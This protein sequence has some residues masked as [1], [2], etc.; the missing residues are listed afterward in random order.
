MI[1]VL[2]GAACGA[3]AGVPRPVPWLD[4]PVRAGWRWL[5]ARLAAAL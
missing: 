4:D 3:G 1:G 5:R 2:S